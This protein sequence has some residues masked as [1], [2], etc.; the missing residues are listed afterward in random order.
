M[1][2]ETRTITDTCIYIYIYYIIYIYI[3]IYGRYV[4]GLTD[5]SPS[6]QLGSCVAK[7]GAQQL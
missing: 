1:V 7:H 2:I 5:N 6:M 3:Y 4:V